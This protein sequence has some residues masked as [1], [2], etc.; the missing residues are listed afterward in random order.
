MR[1]V[2]LD[3]LEQFEIFLEKIEG[4]GYVNNGLLTELEQFGI[5][6]GKVNELI[7]TIK[8]DE[9]VKDGT[10]KLND[11]DLRFTASENGDIFSIPTKLE[12]YLEMWEFVKERQ[13]MFNENEKDAN[14]LFFDVYWNDMECNSAFYDNKVLWV[15]FMDGNVIEYSLYA[16]DENLNSK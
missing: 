3:E 11:F 8:N 14:E 5:F 10:F 2:L 6:V 9:K 15:F 12:D 1:K 16:Y 4:L 7:E 13:K